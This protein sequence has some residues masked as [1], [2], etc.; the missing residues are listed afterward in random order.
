MLSK[1]PKPSHS[2][3]CRQRCSAKE[4]LFPKSGLLR[5]LSP[6]KGRG[7]E[8]N[9]ENRGPLKGEGGSVPGIRDRV[10]GLG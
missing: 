3:G 5:G 2:T 9:C 6:F 7:N 4:I 1:N 10:P 8:N